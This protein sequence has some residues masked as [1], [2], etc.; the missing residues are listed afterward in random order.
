MIATHASCHAKHLSFEQRFCKGSKFE[1]FN[2]SGIS[3][4]GSSITKNILK[5]GMYSCQQKL[6][7]ENKF[8]KGILWSV[9][10]LLSH[11]ITKLF[12][13]KECVRNNG[14][15]IVHNFFVEKGT[16]SFLC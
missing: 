10:Q 1:Y 3:F 4:G 8:K 14:S 16:I 13:T 15:S 6:H 2:K 12:E 9:Q 11:C 5:I 7:L